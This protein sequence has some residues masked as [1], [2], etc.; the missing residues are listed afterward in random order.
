MSAEQQVPVF[1]LDGSQLGLVKLPSV[2][3][4]A[5]RPDLIRRA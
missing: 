1:G 3:Q 5:I 2:F 4:T